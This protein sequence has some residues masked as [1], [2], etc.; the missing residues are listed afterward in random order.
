MFFTIGNDADIYITPYSDSNLTGSISITLY[1]IAVSF[2]LYAPLIHKHGLH[3]GKIYFLLQFGYNISI[4]LLLF[5]LSAKAFR[6]RGTI[7]QTTAAYCTWIGFITTPLLLLIDY[8]VFYFAGP[9]DFISVEK[10]N[11]AN[12]P[13]WANIWEH[14]LLYYNYD[15]LHSYHV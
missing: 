14:R 10:M 1:G 13:I 8:P 12:I 15:N 4:S 6:G 7:R 11:I 2:L 3:L 5:Y 9:D